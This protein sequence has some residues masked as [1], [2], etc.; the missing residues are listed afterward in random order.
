MSCA[1]SRRPWATQDEDFRLSLNAQRELATLAPAA[2]SDDTKWYTVLGT[3]PLRTVFETALGM[4]EGFAALDLDRQLAEMRKRLQATFGDSEIGQFADP[5][6]REDLIRRFLI[7][8][9]TGDTATASGETALALAERHRGV[10]QFGACRALSLICP[11]A[12]AKCVM[13]SGN[14]RNALPLVRLPPRLPAP[15]A[16]ARAVDGSCGN[17]GARGRTRTDTLL[18]AGDFE[19]PCVYHSATRAGRGLPRRLG[20]VNAA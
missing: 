20:P 14:E 6:A 3:P 19:S 1:A 4:P 10:G 16:W 15:R 13:P 2:S 12:T 17:G 9:E 18:P 7:Q 5:Q 8:A 11:D